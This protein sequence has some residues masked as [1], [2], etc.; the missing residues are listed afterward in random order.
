VSSRA[1]QHGT[2]VREERSESGTERKASAKLAEGKAEKERTDGRTK[3]NDLAKKIGRKRA[4]L[5][6]TTEERE[7]ERDSFVCLKLVP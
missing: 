7:R 2:K 1:E 6:V 4:L 3:K 5:R